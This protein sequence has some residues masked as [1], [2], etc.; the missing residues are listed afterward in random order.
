MIFI[1]VSTYQP[2]KSWRILSTN[3]CGEMQRT[4]FSELF[5]DVLCCRDYS[6]RV[7]ASFDHKIK[8]EYYGGNISVSIKGIALEHLV[9]YQRQIS[10]HLHHNVNVMHYF[11]IFYPVIANKILPLL[12]H[13]A[14]VLFHY[15]RRKILKTSLITIWGNTGGCDEQYRCASAI[16]LM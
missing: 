9:H 7:V 13:T 2:S 1:P 3:H 11:I 10:I 8:P 5:Q 16:Y 6:D 14:S 4:A 15:S 12:L